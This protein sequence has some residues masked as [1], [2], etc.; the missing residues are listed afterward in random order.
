M[1]LQLNLSYRGLNDLDVYTLALETR[2]A[3]MMI[4]VDA[5]DSASGHG[6]PGVECLSMFTH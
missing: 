6:G 3:S 5:Q 1:S 2:I 4:T